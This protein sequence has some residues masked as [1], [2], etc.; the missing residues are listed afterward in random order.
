MKISALG[1]ILATFA[2]A[3]SAGDPAELRNYESNDYSARVY[4]RV[5]FG[6]NQREAQSVGL[7]FDNERAAAR[8]APALFQAR[9]GEQGLD[10]LAVNG[11]DLRGAMLSSNQAAGGGFFSSL[12]AA[13]WIALGF[14]TVVF[15]TVA[16]DAA[17]DDPTGTGS[18][19]Y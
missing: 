12:T 19:G 4:Y 1:L 6:G 10:K 18:S 3:A 9:I 7:R 11:V 5:D 8:G 17:D 13:Q 16:Y 15:A 14:T 2:G